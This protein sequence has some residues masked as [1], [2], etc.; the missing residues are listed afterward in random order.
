[1]AQNVIINH[2]TYAEVPSVTIPK[3]D[4]GNAE[5][6]DDSDATALAGEVLSGKTYY[7]GGKQ[8]GQM[9][10]NGEMNG[11][12]NTKMGVV[13]VPAGYTSGGTVAIAASEQEKIIAANIKSG[14]TIL[15]VAGSGMVVDT[16]ISSD[17][18]AAGT[19]LSGKKAFVN[20]VLVTGSVTLPTIS[21]D[22]TTK[23]LT[24]F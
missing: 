9:P 19:I 24:I 12:I 4:G 20:G 18:A 5:F 15:G 16:T 1:M 23:V 21:Q 6:F 8:T 7:H 14:V 13:D 11:V 2:V 3:S 10:N 17:A 22:S